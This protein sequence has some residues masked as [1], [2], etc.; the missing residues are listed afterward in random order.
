MIE[1]QQYIAQFKEY[2]LLTPEEEYRLLRV[3]KT[4]PEGVPP[5]AKEWLL[6]PEQQAAKDLFICSNIRLVIHTAK[7]FTKLEDPKMMDCISAGVS[8][9]VYALN[10]F[11]IDKGVRFS[12][13]ANWWILAKIRSEVRFAEQ[14]I[15][16]YR[17]LHQ[18]YRKLKNSYI[19]EGRLVDDEDLFWELGWTEDE[20]TQFKEDQQRL[21]ISLDTLDTETT[22]FV[23]VDSA[24]VIEPVQE[25]V[26]DDLYSAEQRTLLKSA[27]RVLTKQEARIIEGRYALNGVEKTFDELAEELHIPREKIRQIKAKALYKLWRFIRNQAPSMCD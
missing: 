10:M 20:I 9:M 4:P 26:I 25:E 17:T 3:I 18:Q 6:T 11:D 5:D 1:V 2:P 24:F 13:Y 22:D 21:R 7:K 23:A 12:T 14:K 16:R 19:K 15:I 27:L 8:G